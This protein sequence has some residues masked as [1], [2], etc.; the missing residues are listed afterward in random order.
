MQ[1]ALQI[2]ARPAILARQR[3]CNIAGS[4][5]NLAPEA[6]PVH[7]GAQT[8]RLT[9]G[10]LGSPCTRFVGVPPFRSGTLTGLFKAIQ[11]GIEHPTFVDCFDMRLSAVVD[12]LDRD[13]HQRISAVEALC[14]LE[15][16]QILLPVQRG[17]CEVHFW[18]LAAKKSAMTTRKPSF[19][20]QC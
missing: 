19:F 17:C 11:S 10:Q 6:L 7:P 2:F 8:C 15:R 5:T 1:S 16:G 20:T 4:L 18:P 9:F 14:L 12:S 3:F 13:P